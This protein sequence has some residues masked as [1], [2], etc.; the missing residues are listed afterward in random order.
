MVLKNTMELYKTD[1]ERLYTEKYTNSQKGRLGYE[2]PRASCTR[3]M[4]TNIKLGYYAAVGEITLV[5]LCTQSF[6]PTLQRTL[7]S[8]GPNVHQFPSL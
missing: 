1:G 3:L 5:A 2:S 8:S 6:T 4:S 7:S